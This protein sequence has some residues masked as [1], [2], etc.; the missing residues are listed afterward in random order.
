MGHYE[1]R[2][3]R[4]KWVQWLGDFLFDHNP[5]VFF[6]EPG[7][8]LQVIVEEG[9]FGPSY[10]FSGPNADNSRFMAER[11]PHF[12]GI[13]LDY[14]ELEVEDFKRQIDQQ[15]RDQF[16]LLAEG[17]KKYALS[18]SFIDHATAYFNYE[19]ARLMISYPRNY[20]RVNGRKNREITPEYYD[21]LQEIP[22]VDEKAIGTMEYSIFLTRTLDW[23][24]FKSFE[25]R[26][27][28]LSEQYD[29]LGLALS[30]E[31]QAQLDSLYEKDG[32]QPV[33]SKMVDLS[34]FG[35]SESA[36]AQLDSLYEKDGRW[37]KPSERYDLSGFG[38]SESAQ[39]QLDSLYEKSGRS[40]RITSL[41]EGETPRADTTGGTFVFRPFRIAFLSEGETPRAD[42]TGGTFVFY[43]P[44]GVR[45]DSLAKEPPKLS[46]KLD[47]SDL[48]LSDA[49]Q[50]QL[51]SMYEHRQPLL[52]LS[53][54]I[55]L[56]G[57]GLSEAA[58][59]QLDSIYV[60]DRGHYLPSGLPRI[61]RKES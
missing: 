36:Q 41:S 43:I 35:V 40:F 28:K 18:P 21:F 5:L 51:D 46:A 20:H 44:R 47:L 3:P 50:A 9:F 33:L 22:L 14:K 12:R 53:A 19:W 60:A 34:G 15:R 16:E 17:R 29:L 55:D 39:A 56:S 57:L 37:L 48:G 30:E 2:Q 61:G 11:F 32:F 25:S 6:V 10:S 58:Q 26:L 45:L 52:K 59:A 13:R 38:V 54:K 27:P 31:T 1:E 49:A 4:W 42:T 8:S 23:E 24:Y 7:D